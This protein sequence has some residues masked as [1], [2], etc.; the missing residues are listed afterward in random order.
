MAKSKKKQKDTL[1]P[2]DGIL[3]TWLD[4]TGS[5]AWSSLHD[6]PLEPVTVRQLG[7]FLAKDTKTLHIAQGLPTEEC[8]VL[9]LC[10]IPLGCV[11]SIKKLKL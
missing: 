2:G 10:V 8:Q 4:T 7:F 6:E 5:G 1:I 3:V 11:T 9:G